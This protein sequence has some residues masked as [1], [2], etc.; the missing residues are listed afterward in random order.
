M[1]DVALSPDTLDVE[2]R[3]R[4]EAPAPDFPGVHTLGV[5]EYGPRPAGPSLTH[6]G[7]EL[8]VPMAAAE[9]DGFAEVWTT[10]RPVRTGY[11]RG[12]HYAYD[13]E[14]LFCAG[15]LPAARSYARKT[16]EAYTALLELAG[17]LGYHSLFRMW[18]FIGRINEDNA[19][20]LE[21]YRDFCLGRATAFEKSRYP[22]RRLSAATGIGALGEGISFCALSAKSGICTPLENPRQIAAYHYPPKYG[23]KSPSFARA[24]HVRHTAAAAGT[25]T[26]EDAPP[27]QDAPTHDRLY[28]SGTASIVGHASVHAGRIEEQ[29]R[30]TLDNI[31]GVI[32]DANAAAHG[33]AH[34]YRLTDLY[35][36]KVYVRHAEHLDAVRRLCAEAFAPEA[37]IAYLNVDICRSDLLV[38][39]EG[40]AR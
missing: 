35:R 25:G 21:V 6:R 18:N 33:L 14:H 38:E 30:T 40:I 7:V 13:G 1:T 8:T 17:E 36:A 5:V 37:E 10:T 39:I 27:P 3:K 26:A 19:E 15:H 29:V 24:T 22:L 23:P 28:V 11:H 12:I 20:R 9:A 34:G 2:F 4:T 32:G 16:E 31:A